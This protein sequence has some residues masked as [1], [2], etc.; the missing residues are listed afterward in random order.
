MYNVSL[1]STGFHVSLSGVGAQ[2]AAG[3]SAYTHAVA[4]GYLGTELQ[5]NTYLADLPTFASAA[6]NSAMAAAVSATSAED[7][8]ESALT[9]AATAITKSDQAS[10]SAVAAATSA[11]TASSAS[12]AATTSAEAALASQDSATFSAGTATAQATIATTQADLSRDWATKTSSEVVVGQGFGALKYASDAAASA[13]VTVTKATEASTSATNAASS[14]AVAVTKASEASASATNAA[15]RETVAI[16]KAA[17]ASTS[18]TNAASSETVAI[19]KASEASASATSAASSETGAIN[20]ANTASTHAGNA[21]IA[22]STATTHANKA[23]QWADADLNV[24]VESG[25]YSAKHWAAQ[26]QASVIGAVV[27][28]GAYSA[29]SGLYPPNPVSG[30]WYK[31]SETGTLGGVVHVVGDSIVYDGTTWDKIGNTW[32]LDTASY[33]PALV[34]GVNIKTVNGQSVLGSGDLAISGGGG[35]A[36][37]EQTF[38][39]MGA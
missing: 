3:V 35:A 11:I 27:Y 16:T 38:L 24:Q 39:L 32:T 37:F 25:K 23:Q 21:V 34:S 18:A 5:F 29:A 14:E 22:A 20:A 17:E 6:A 28:R 10:A 1:T 13:A 19:A 33:Q 36:G 8:A 4:G 30:D 26:A 7:S 15:S 9:S 12:V 2:G 31:I